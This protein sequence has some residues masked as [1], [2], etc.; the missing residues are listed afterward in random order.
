[1]ADHGNILMTHFTERTQLHTCD[2]SAPFSVHWL[3]PAW[4]Q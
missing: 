1:M 4:S 2:N 3:A